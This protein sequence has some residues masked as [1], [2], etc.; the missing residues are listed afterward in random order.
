MDRNRNVASAA[1][2]LAFGGAFNYLFYGRSAGISLP[3]FVFLALA[4]AT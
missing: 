3:L 1:L 2:A 4:T